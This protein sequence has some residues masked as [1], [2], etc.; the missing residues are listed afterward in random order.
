MIQRALSHHRQMLNC[1]KSGIKC[2]IK[3]V[4]STAGRAIIK[5]INLTGQ[6]LLPRIKKIPESSIDAY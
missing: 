6:F 2:L 3:N 5:P 4:G 1:A